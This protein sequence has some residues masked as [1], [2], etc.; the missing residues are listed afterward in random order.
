M[1]RPRGGDELLSHIARA[2]MGDGTALASPLLVCL[3]EEQRLS[4]E[5][6]RTRKENTVLREQVACHLRICDIAV[7]LCLRDDFA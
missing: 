3:Q 2:L 5:I 7:A 1:E 4:S 6:E